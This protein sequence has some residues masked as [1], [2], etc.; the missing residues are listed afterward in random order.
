MN[1]KAATIIALIFNS[2]YT[3]SLVQNLINIISRVNFLGG[4]MASFVSLGF[5]ILAHA[6]LAVFLLVF[7]SRPLPKDGNG[8]RVVAEGQPL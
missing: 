7:D 8:P 5:G 4:N 6:S 1:L 2:L 3:L